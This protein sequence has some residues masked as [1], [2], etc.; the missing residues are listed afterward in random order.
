[1]KRWISS[2]IGAV[3]GVGVV[4]VLGVVSAVFIAGCSDSMHSNMTNSTNKSTYSSVGERI[5]FTGQSGSGTTIGAIGGHHHM[6]MHGGSCVTCHGAD[7][8][9]G[10]RMWPWF[11]VTAP[12]L[13]QSAL[14]G[15]HEDTGHSHDVYDASSLKRAITDG[16]NPAG[17]Q[18]DD[19]MPRWQ[20]SEQDMD[21]L[22]HFLLGSHSVRGH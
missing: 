3:G 13:T 11:W 2:A 14:L 15:D 7:R 18:L 5:Y 22:V 10:G 19:L 4:G 1:M 6:Q 21:E 17:E 20:M 16:V 8:E 9:G 12:S